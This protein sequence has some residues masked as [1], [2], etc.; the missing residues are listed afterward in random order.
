MSEKDIETMVEINPYNRRARMF[1]SMIDVTEH[2]YFNKIYEI[3]Y[4]AGAFSKVMKMAELLRAKG[5]EKEEIR[6]MINEVMGKEVLK[7]K[8]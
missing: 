1:F 5:I 7:P 4:R 6:L 8:E 2:R 3:G